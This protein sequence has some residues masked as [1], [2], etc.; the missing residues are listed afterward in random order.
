MNI[1][2]D[3]V[4]LRFRQR[5]SG[6][7]AIFLRYYVNGQRKEES[8]KLY[9]VPEATRE[10][11]RKNKETIAVAEAV[12]ARKVVEI[13]NEVF[14]FEEKEIPKICDYIQKKADSAK[15]SSSKQTLI[16]ILRL[17]EKFD[18]NKKLDVLDKNWA[19]RFASFVRSWKS[20]RTKKELS[21]NSQAVYLRNFRALLETAKDECLIKQ[22][23]FIGIDIPAAEDTLRAYLTVEEL[24]RLVATPT[25][26]L[27]VRR[28]FLFSCH[29]G[30]R[31]SDVR[32]LCWGDIIEEGNQVRAVIKQ[33]KTKC[34]LYLYL[35]EMAVALM[36]KREDSNIN[37][38]PYIPTSPTIQSV[39][40][41]WKSCAGIEK[42]ITFHTARHTFAT[43][44]LNEG[45]DLYTVSQLL[46]HANI[47]TT[48]IYAKIIDKTKKEAILKFPKL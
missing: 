7:T 8:L 2:K 39:L 22:N 11:K 47:G 48:Q 21:S 3:F 44:L 17:V 38:F 23:P 34:V 37:V 32:N 42:H 20:K 9:L 33:K 46:G 15:S 13:Q 45:V 4:T 28:A 24:K 36:G 26:N 5:E 31:I 41:K 19:A 1:R 18:D 6:L 43:I 10:D 14:S 25:D 27:E 35:S 30:L 12:L 40:D 16:N 29:T